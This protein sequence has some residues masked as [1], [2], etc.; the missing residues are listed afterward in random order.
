MGIVG[1]TGSGHRVLAEIRHFLFCYNLSH[2]ASS[3][4]HNKTIFLKFKT[5]GGGRKRQGR[6]GWSHQMA[7][8]SA[9]RVV[10]RGVG[11]GVWAPEI[12]GRPVQPGT[13]A[14]RRDAAA[15]PPGVTAAVPACQQGET[16]TVA[17]R[18]A[19]RARPGRRKRDVG[20]RGPGAA[21]PA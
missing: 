5:Q 6:R 14:G 2:F 16:A 1:R 18:D 12:R 4:P 3:R 13:T 9:A 21:G 7:P 19:G 11:R 17:S 8:S 10:H 20:A 15:G